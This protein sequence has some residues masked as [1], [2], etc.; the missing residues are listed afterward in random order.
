MAEV[1]LL[2][3][4]SPWKPLPS[5]IDWNAVDNGPAFD[6]MPHDGI[7]PDVDPAQIRADYQQS[8]VYS[9]STLISYVRTY[10][11]NNLVLVF[12]GDHQPAP[13][14][15][16]QGA[17]RDVPVTVVAHDPAVLDRISGWGWQEGLNPTPQA[18]VWPMDAFRDRF[19]NAFGPR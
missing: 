19:L 15:T 4:H 10:G 8:I 12:A 13:V 14:V 2:S 11:D 18:P 6:A 1:V 9:L 3:S 5:V 7:K 16:G 17:S